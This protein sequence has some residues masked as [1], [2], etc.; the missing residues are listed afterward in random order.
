MESK[1]EKVSLGEIILKV[2]EERDD[3]IAKEIFYSLRN[4]AF[5]GIINPYR[6]RIEPADLQS[7]GND[8]QISDLPIIFTCT[9]K[10]ID[11]SNT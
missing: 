5:V 6:A 8:V 2:E 9:E 10:K 7:R 3:K 4:G 1:V 11:F